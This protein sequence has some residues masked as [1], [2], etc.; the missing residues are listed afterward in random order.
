MV[1]GPAS[2]VERSFSE[3]KEEAGRAWNIA[4]GSLAAEWARNTQPGDLLE[5]AVRA[6]TLVPDDSD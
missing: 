1:P 3:P 2:S 4:T 5:L 6:A